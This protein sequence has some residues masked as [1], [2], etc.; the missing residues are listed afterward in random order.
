MTEAR[1]LK[2]RQMREWEE[3]RDTII[4]NYTQYSYYGKS[5]YLMINF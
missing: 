1:V 4:F 2:K 3:K 5:V